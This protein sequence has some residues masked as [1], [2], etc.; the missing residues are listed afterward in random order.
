MTNTKNSRRAF[1]GKMGAL[2]V[3]GV[4]AMAGC[5]EVV[6]SSVSPSESLQS[7]N[8]FASTRYDFYGKHQ[9][10]IITPT[11]RHIYFLVVDLHSANKQEIAQMFKAWTDY[12]VRLMKGENVQAYD[13]NPHVPPIDTGEADSLGAYGLTLTFGVSPSFFDKL[14]LQDKKPP[15]LSEL[16]KFPRD[17]IR[18]ELSGGDICIQAC[19]E[20]PQVAFHAVRQLVRQA[21]DKI[22]MK[23]SQSG[24]NAFDDNK[25]TPRNLFAFKDGT[26][27]QDTLN[28]TDK[29]LWTNDQGWFEGGTYLVVRVIQMHLETWDRT[30]LKGQEDTFGRHRD[31]GAAIGKLG[32]FD[33]FDV[34]AKDDK[35]DLV[36]AETTHVGLAK[37]TGLKLLRRSFSY[38]S[39]IDPKTGQ[40]NAGLLFISF[41]KQPIQFSVI[42]NAFGNTDKMA[43]YTTHIGSGLFACFGGVKEGEY[44]GQKL[45]ES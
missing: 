29:W 15:E 37:R 2:S 38:S 11:Q 16:P 21:R 44:L 5:D 10:G 34:Q 40:F 36:I 19:S 9:S 8:C 25:D 24:F 33:E 4:G 23:W 17:Q 13:V 41:Q 26:A 39:G 31:S 28:D 43:E 45:F 42:Q 35:G 6:Q 22:T 18:P 32:E 3:L 14:G 1:L 20:D 30:S 7:K 12:S 27:N